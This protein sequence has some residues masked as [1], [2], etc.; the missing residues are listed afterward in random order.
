[1][2]LD[3]ETSVDLA[4]LI[5]RRRGWIV[6]G[7]TLAVLG[8]VP[9]AAHVQRSLEVAA[10]VRGSESAV[11]EAEL[12]TRFG[13]PYA[14]YAVLVCRGLPS[15]LD[16][17]GRVVM[18]TLIA[19]IAAVPGV[20]RVR[21]Y[22][23]PSDTLFI[24]SGDTT[25]LILVGLDGV[26]RVP[27]DI[28]PALRAT[29]RVLLVRFAERYPR[30]TLRWTGQAA[31]NAD[32]RHTSAAAATRAERRALPLTLLLLVLAFGTFVA[33]ALPVLAGALTIT[34]ALGGAAL[35]SRAWPLSILIQN[36]IT[37]VGLGLGI[38]YALLVVSRFREGLSGGRTAPEA[39]VDAARHAGRTIVLSGAAVGIGFLAMLAV[40]LAEMRSLAV[41]GVLAVVTAILL[42]T[43]L[44]PA[45][46]AWLGG[47]I[48]RGR[49]WGTPAPLGGARWRRWGRW[50]TRHPVA[51]LILAGAPVVALAWQAKRMHAG[52]PHGDWL[53]PAMESAQGWRDLERMG[54]SN[55]L[56]TIR[57]LVDLPAGVDPIAP[58]GWAVLRRIR[59]RLLAEPRIG[60]VLSFAPLDRERPPSR[61]AFFV[62]PQATR[63]AYVT[64]DRRAVLLEAVPREGVDPVA[65]VALARALRGVDDADMAGMVGVRVRIG[66]LPAFRADYLDAVGGR[67]PLVMAL[68]IGAT[69]AALFVGFGSLVIPVKALVLNLLSVAAGFGA[70]VVVF[71]DGVGASV[72]GLAAPV[73][74]VFAVIPTL[75]FCTVF[76]LSM[77][78]EVFLVARIAEARR[79]GG[80]ERESLV[81]GLAHTAPVITSAAAIMVVVFGAFTLGDFLVM[82]MLGL[83]LAVAVLLDAT[84]VRTAIG[85]ALLTLAGRWNWWPGRR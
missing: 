21:G 61:L 33:A 20:T 27:D 8:A 25:A 31:L 9:L 81:D 7:W 5:V 47:A 85:P 38:D 65:L 26:T 10:R 72:L 78:Y 40:P 69:F 12:A 44:L 57:V 36:F 70:V 75:V 17:D 14:Q 34:I 16:P 42:S 63:A 3:L 18:D 41:G 66:G 23:R 22:E 73:D 2:E 59:Q 24:A 60:T 77:D 46:L 58:Q 4:G 54:R 39:A 52:L 29:T 19:A 37:M 55:M 43:T 50:V 13:A 71:Q 11:V 15:P 53:P 30:V 68:V 45:L 84:L 1:M 67:L 80:E 62:T 74:S 56:Q 35:I 48:D 51:V 79:A 64:A 76:G 83:A 49:L 82:Q 28:I 6:A 32:L